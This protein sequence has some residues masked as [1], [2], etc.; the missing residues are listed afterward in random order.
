MLLEIVVV[1]LVILLIALCANLLM[2]LFNPFMDGGWNPHDDISIISVYRTVEPAKNVKIR[3]KVASYVALQGDVIHVVPHISMHHFPWVCETSYGDVLMSHGVCFTKY[4][5]AD[6]SIFAAVSMVEYEHYVINGANYSVGLNIHKVFHDEN[7]NPIYNT[8]CVYGLEAGVSKAISENF[9]AVG[10]F[11]MPEGQPQP[12]INKVSINK[13][14]N[15]LYSV[16][17]ERYP[18]CK[19]VELYMEMND[20]TYLDYHTQVVPRHLPVVNKGK[21]DLTKMINALKAEAKNMRAQSLSPPP[22]TTPIMTRPS[23]LSLP[24]PPTNILPFK[25]TSAAFIPTFRPKSYSPPPEPCGDDAKVWIVYN[26]KHVV[27]EALKDPTR[28]DIRITYYTQS[29]PMMKTFTAVP[30]DSDCF[31]DALCDM[32]KATVVPPYMQYEGIMERSNV[33][34]NAAIACYRLGVLISEMVPELKQWYETRDVPPTIIANAA[35]GKYYVQYRGAPPR[36]IY[37]TDIL[38]PRGMRI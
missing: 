30:H 19:G 1:F 7:N 27:V 38:Q 4:E 31:R 11:V 21:R 16:F 3:L 26:G 5:L 32:C 6:G 24:P 10:R 9:T 37:R 20:S 22:I 35:E 33:I 15:G 28:A 23:S 18:Q 13:T 34:N 36:E 12:N 8:V 14:L 25:Q 29:E 17:L 2:R